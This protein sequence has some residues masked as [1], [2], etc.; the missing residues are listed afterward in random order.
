M[1]KDDILPDGQEISIG[2]AI[3]LASAAFEQAGLTF[4]HGTTQAFDEA[5]WLLLEALGQSPLVQPDYDQMLTNA[6]RADCNNVLFVRLHERQPAAYIT[7]RAWFA[8]LEFRCDS[9]ALV[10]RS[11]LAQWITAD[12]Y[13]LLDTNSVSRVLDLC[14]GGGCIAIACA[15]ALPHARIDASDLSATALQ[16]ARLNV[17]DHALEERVSLVNCSLFE[18]LTGPYDLIVSNPPYVD[19][20]DLA[21]MPGEFRHEPAMALAAG[22][23]GLDLVRVILHQA[24]EYLS[25]NGLLV[26]EV[27]NSAATLEQSYPNVPFL[28]LEFEHGGSGVFVLT[29]AELEAHADAM[30][31]GL[32]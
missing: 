27:G 4:G 25:E 14:T 31:A 3:H 26:V 24:A 16:L 11:P 32:I 15:Y 19:A 18:A 22:H 10:P 2:Q 9:R 30:A 1:P 17:V 21:A 13:A 5:S 20:V 8:G 7:G 23:D 28:W 6:E 12:F 29:K